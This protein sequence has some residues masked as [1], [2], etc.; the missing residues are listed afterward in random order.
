MSSRLAQSFA[1]KYQLNYDACNKEI[2]VYLYVCTAWGFFQLGGGV[3][4]CHAEHGK[5][6]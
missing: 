4:L 1:V 2:R 3:C 5:P 6:G